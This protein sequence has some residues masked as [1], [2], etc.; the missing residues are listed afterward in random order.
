MRAD[1]LVNSS[2][3]PAGR[4]D[5]TDQRSYPKGVSSRGRG[6]IQFR[7]RGRAKYSGA[8]PPQAAHKALLSQ[9]T[10]SHY[11]I[12]N[13]RLFLDVKGTV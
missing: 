3:R 9:S 11:M 8:V 10:R 12:E 4:E 6:S 7:S 5:V 2:S 13:S 1:N